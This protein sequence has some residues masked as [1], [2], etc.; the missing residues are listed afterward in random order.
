MTNPTDL[1]VIWFKGILFAV[2]GLLASGLLV[3]PL[4]ASPSVVDF[5]GPDS[6]DRKDFHR[7][8]S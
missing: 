5:E 3:S 1:R 7:F 8:H 2:L 4:V 6:C